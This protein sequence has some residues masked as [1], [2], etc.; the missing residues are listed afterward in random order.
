MNES[1][2]TYFSQV[3]ANKVGKMHKYKVGDVV[4]VASSVRNENKLMKYALQWKFRGSVADI[5]KA[6]YIRVHWLGNLIAG[7][8]CGLPSG[9]EE[10]EE[11]CV[12]GWI[13]RAMVSPSRL[14]PS[15]ATDFP[16]NN[17]SGNLQ[18]KV[19]AAEDS[20]D[21]SNQ[22]R[23]MERFGFVLVDNDS[24]KSSIDFAEDNDGWG[25]YIDITNRI[26][27]DGSVAE[28]V[29]GL[30]Q[31]WVVEDR[32]FFSTFLNRNLSCAVDAALEV[33]QVVFIYFTYA[34]HVACNEI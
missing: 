26:N 19:E 16:S 30:V 10:A 1:I 3:I 18:L 14:E 23:S 8:A 28:H 11:G 4:R 12:S 20:I 22:L 6:G 13:P 15:V 17:T 25:P 29:P 34:C 33:C 2:T 9:G 32:A 24:G 5:T 7:E 21:V 31:D 27:L